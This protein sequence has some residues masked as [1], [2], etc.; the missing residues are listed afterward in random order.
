M[1]GTPRRSLPVIY[2]RLTVTFLCH[3][4]D[5]HQERSVSAALDAA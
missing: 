1:Y 3:S 2:L 5:V 4:E